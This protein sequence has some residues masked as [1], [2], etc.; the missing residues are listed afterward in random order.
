[1]LAGRFRRHSLASFVSPRLHRSLF[2]HGSPLPRWLALMFL[3]AAS[4]A[5]VVAL[6]R[7]QT[8]NGTRAEKS[9]GR[10]LLIAL[11]ISRSMRVRDV[12]PDR[13]SLAKM[14]ICELLD[15][16]PND[17]VGLI[18][19]AGT[20]YVYAP[21]TIDHDAVRETVEQ[22]DETWA[23][24]GGSD[25]TSAVRL[26]LETLKKTGQKNNALVILS[27]GENHEGHLNEM[28]A[29]AESSGVR[30]IAIGVGTPDG[31]YVPSQDFKNQHM[32]DRGGKPVISRLQSDVMRRLA[33]ETHGRYVV[34][35][36][37]MDIPA[38]VKSTMMD[39]DTFEIEGRERS[40]RIEFYQWLVL[41]AIL[42]LLAAIL[43]STRWRAVGITALASMFCLTSIRL[44]AD[45]VSSA[46]SALEQ[47]RYQDATNVY[48]SLAT[49]AW[50]GERAARFRLGEGIAA[51]RGMDLKRARSAFSGALLAKDSEVL[52]H[53][54]LGMGNTL[55]QLGWICLTDKTYPHDPAQL[56]GLQQFDALVKARLATLKKSLDPTNDEPGAYARMDE[57]MT[58][59]ADA[60]RHFESAIALN[61]WNITSR[62]NLNLTML[63][64]HRLRKLLEDD[65]EQARQ[66]LPQTPPENGKSEQDARDPKDKSDRKDGENQGPKPPADKRDNDTG[67][68]NDSSNEKDK[69]DAKSADQKEEKDKGKTDPNETPEQR[70]RR[71]LKENADLEKGPLTPGRREFQPPKQDW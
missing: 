25:L 9:L 22:I 64:L 37:G 54:H 19:F 48:G 28:I 24:L 12:K 60:T 47:M 53:G 31:D 62:N 27:D 35:G 39:L 69:S 49:S 13:L 51:Y 65:L 4:A 52:T 57:L 41:P 10:N 68:K 20:S 6:A 38:M 32:M 26:A 7:P 63:Y 45:E 42:F 30:V 58:N 21:L 16:M 8:D 18:G 71:I 23:P 5:I 11:D 3:L 33:S 29:A 40:I 14:V 61:P 43:A 67:P 55:F 59:W 50:S 70:A 1:M 15:A 2:L 66:E 17:R 46:R 36:T 44:R 56:P 34:A